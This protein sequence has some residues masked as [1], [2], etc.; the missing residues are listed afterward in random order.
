MQWAISNLLFLSFVALV[1]CL[2]VQ[3]LNFSD[4]LSPGKH[5]LTFPTPGTLEKFFSTLSHHIVP[6]LCPL[7]RQ[8]S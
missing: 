3:S 7:T 1:L 8:K 5:S 2:R 6:H 4:A